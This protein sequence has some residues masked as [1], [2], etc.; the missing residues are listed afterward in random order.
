LPPSQRTSHA[1]QHGDGAQHQQPQLHQH[2]HQTQY[3]QQHTRVHQNGSTTI[4][5]G[6]PISIDAIGQKAIEKGLRR[7]DTPARRVH[8]HDHNARLTVAR[9]T[10]GHVG[11][12]LVDLPR[13]PPAQPTNPIGSVQLIPPDNSSSNTDA[14]PTHDEATLAYH[15]LRARQQH[16]QQQQQQQQQ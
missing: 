12:A 1:P 6:K 10:L 11:H 8:L 2:Q 13:D 5:D 9:R 16:Q 3:Q 14:Q 7:S 4:G 15:T